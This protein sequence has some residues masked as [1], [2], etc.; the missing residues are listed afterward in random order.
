VP[1]YVAKLLFPNLTSDERRRKMRAL[2]LGIVVAIL[3][4]GAVA[5]L[6][7]AVYQRA[8]P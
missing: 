1:R 7:Y 4:A 3:A 2:Q 6:I 8:R 5:F